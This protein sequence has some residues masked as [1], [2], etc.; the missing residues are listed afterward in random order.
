M[1]IFLV[2]DDTFLLDMYAAKFSGTGHTVET[3]K[4]VE[5]A[6]EKLRGGGMYDALLLDMVLPGMTGLDL[7]NAVRTEKLAVNAKA[8]VLSNQGDQTDIDAAM[9]AGAHGYIVKA[10]MIPSEVVAKVVSIV[11]NK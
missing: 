1:K 7:L 5:E 2:D 10:H 4:S 8:I 3:A 11:E 9:A 6:L